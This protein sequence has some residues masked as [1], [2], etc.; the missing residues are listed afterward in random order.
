MARALIEGGASDEKAVLVLPDVSFNNA[1]VVPPIGREPIGVIPT[2]QTSDFFLMLNLPPDAGIIGC[3]EMT[4]YVQVQQIGGF[5]GALH[6][7]FGDLYFGNTT[8]GD[9][10]AEFRIADRRTGFGLWSEHRN[11]HQK[12]EEDAA[13]DQEA[14]EPRIAVRLFVVHRC[15]D[16]AVICPA[17]LG[18]NG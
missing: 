7:V 5:P 2:H 11:D 8:F 12:G 14:L 6:A 13:P 4:H 18:A 1:F 10:V 15:R 16:P 3:H 9:T 17:Y